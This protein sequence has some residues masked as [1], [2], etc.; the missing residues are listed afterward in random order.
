MKVSLHSRSLLSSLDL[1]V[2]VFDIFKCNFSELFYSNLP[3]KDFYNTV[4]HAGESA[5][6]Y[7]N[8]LNKAVDA[9]DECLRGR[10]RSVENPS[11]ELVKMFINNSS[12]PSLDVYFQL[13]APEQWTAAEVQ[14]HLDSQRDM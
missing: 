3:M 10:G 1:P 7:W 4:P 9:A 5:M 8:R 6:H 11:A 12:D 13:K 14:E 2:A